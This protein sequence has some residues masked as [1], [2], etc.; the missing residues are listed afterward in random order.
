MRPLTWS[1]SLEWGYG[2]DYLLWLIFCE[3][4]EDSPTANSAAV[5]FFFFVS[6][7]FLELATYGVDP[8]SN[9]TATASF[10]ISPAPEG[11]VFGMAAL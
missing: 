7:S 9:K 3:Q 5:F 4:L 2:E 11:T 10:L 6:V 8:S 1:Q